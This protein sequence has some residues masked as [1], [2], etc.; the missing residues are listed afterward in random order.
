MCQKSAVNAEVRLYDRLFNV[1]NPS[2]ESSGSFIDNLNPNSVE[3]L[4]NCKLEA[5][6]A[7]IEPGDKYQFLRLGY[8]CADKDSTPERIVLNRTAA[9]KDSWAKINK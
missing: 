3:T 6:L 4:E 7:G 9:L 2:D 5:G 8:F 1:E